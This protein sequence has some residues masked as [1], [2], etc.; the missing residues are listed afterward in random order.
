MKFHP[1]SLDNACLITLPKEMIMAQTPTMRAAIARQI[2]TGSNKLVMDLHQVEYID[3]SG[4]S[5]LVSAHKLTQ[6]RS[7]EVILLSPSAGV[8][9]LIELTRLHH[10]FTIF[11]DKDAAI[12][13]IC[14]Q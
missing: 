2:E 4:L 3:S 9:A 13:H 1:L 14:A 7:G 8:R 6:Q 10:I 5:I 12:E 11:E